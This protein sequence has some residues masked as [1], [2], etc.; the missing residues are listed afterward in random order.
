MGRRSSIAALVVAAQV[1]LSAQTFLTE[2]FNAVPDS[3]LRRNLDGLIPNAG[4]R[5]TQGASN[6]RQL[7][8][9]GVVPE[10]S[11]WAL[12][13]TGFAGLALISRRRRPRSIA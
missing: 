2:T 3:M 13:V 5:V 1:S 10:P 8:Q 6:V 11:T 7:V 4:I 9:P 12:L